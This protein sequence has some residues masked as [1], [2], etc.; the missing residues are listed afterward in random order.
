MPSEE[1]LDELD[2]GDALAQLIHETLRLQTY[3]APAQLQAVLAVEIANVDGNLCLAL[4]DLHLDWPLTIVLILAL[5]VEAITLRHRCPLGANDRLLEVRLLQLIVELDA[6]SVVVVEDVS[7][8]GRGLLCRHG[9]GLV[10]GLSVRLNL[11]LDHTHPPGSHI[12]EHGYKPGLALC[13]RWGHV[14]FDEPQLKVLIYNEVEAIQLERVLPILDNFGHLR[15]SRLY[16]VV[17][18]WQEEV[19][20]RDFTVLLRILP[21]EVFDEV[22]TTQYKLVVFLNT[23]IRYVTLSVLKL[24]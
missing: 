14:H 2:C 12:V 8:D 22:I 16:D 4:W 15:E 23:I 17:N 13:A 18:L 21:P 11:G 3:R 10:E 7:E 1:L 24:T 20:P 5:Q 9:E 6:S 19:F